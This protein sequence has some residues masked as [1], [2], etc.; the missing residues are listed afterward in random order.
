[1]IDLKLDK[2]KDEL[3]QTVRYGKVTFTEKVGKRNRYVFSV[4]ETSFSFQKII[5]ED[6]SYTVFSENLSEEIEKQV[7]TL[8]KEYL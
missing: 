6:D 7:I 8:I 3:F 1:M 5:Y 4:G 2:L